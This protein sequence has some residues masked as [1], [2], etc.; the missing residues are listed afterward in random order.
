MPADAE[1]VQ[2]LSDALRARG[3]S[4]SQLPVGTATNPFALTFTLEARLFRA[5]VHVRLLTPQRGPGTDHHRGADEWHT[6]MIFDDSRRGRGVRNRLSR[7]PGYRTVLLGYSMIGRTLVIAAWD[8]IRRAE[9]A[10]SR[11]LQIRERT[12]SQAAEFGVGQQVSRG[13]EIV[14]AFRA[15]FFPE[16]LADAVDLHAIVDTSGEPDTE[17]DIPEDFFGPRDRRILSGTRALRDVRFKSFVARH[18]EMCAVCGLDASALLQAAH[19]IPVADPRSSDHPSN[20]VRL[21]RNCHALFDAGILLI[22]PDYTIE[23][24]KGVLEFGTRASETYGAFD[25]AR[26][27]LPRV[28]E[29][30]LPSPEKLA[31]TY[32]LRRQWN[33]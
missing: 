27:R 19:V 8:V 24:V 21:C 13:G 26:L 25:G 29:E 20:G 16:Y 18:Y 17:D 14:V 32:E 23:I 2:G 30:F 7:K 15:E 9:Y 22:R 1:I 33:V 6:Q 11:S 3:A 12:L 28:R 4:I 5:L 31:A 10:Y